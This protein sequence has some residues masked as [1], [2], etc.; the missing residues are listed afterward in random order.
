[1]EVLRIFVRN[2]VME[3][4]TKTSHIFYDF[5][6]VVHSWDISNPSTRSLQRPFFSF[7][8]TYQT[9]L[10]H[11]K[12]YPPPPPKSPLHIHTTSHPTTALPPKSPSINALSIPGSSLTKTANTS[13]G[14]ASPN[15]WARFHRRRREMPTQGPYCDDRSKWRRI[16]SWRE[17]DFWWTG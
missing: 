12:N 5:E 6:M 7:H 16:F 8:P 10:Y 13:I 17:R 11:T 4:R 2:G 1:M 14:G 3:A 9:P 15:P